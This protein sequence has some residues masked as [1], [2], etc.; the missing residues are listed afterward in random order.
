[1][2]HEVAGRVVHEAEKNYQSDM[3][4]IP[5]AQLQK[6]S[7]LFK[8]DIQEIWDYQKSVD[9]YE[10]H[11]GTGSSSVKK[12]ISNFRAFLEERGL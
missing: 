5:L 10:C 7:P 2:A 8:E 12:Q 4:K 3:S 11:G 6:I 9:Q 1:L